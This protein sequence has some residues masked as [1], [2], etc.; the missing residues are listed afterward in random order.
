MEWDI[1]YNTTRDDLVISE[2]G[3]GVQDLLRKANEVEDDTERQAYVERVIRLMLQIQPEVKT[4]G[5]YQERLWR[6]AFL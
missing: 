6:H 1:A 2:Y 3:R 5:N 4:Q